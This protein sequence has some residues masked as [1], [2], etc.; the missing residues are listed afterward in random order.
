MFQSLIRVYLRVIYVWSVSKY[1][2][3]HQHIIL[4]KIKIVQ[5]RKLK[6]IIGGLHSLDDD[7]VKILFWKKLRKNEKK[8]VLLITSYY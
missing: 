4:V 6:A 1:I 3:L 7:D 8:N 2:I 5:S